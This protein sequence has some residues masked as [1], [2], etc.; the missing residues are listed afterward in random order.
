MASTQWTGSLV[1]LSGLSFFCILVTISSNYGL[2]YGYI[3][4][5][6]LGYGN[7]MINVLIAVWSTF[8]PMGNFIGALVNDRVGRVL[9]MSEYSAACRFDDRNDALTYI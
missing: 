1:L 2:D 3:V 4:Y 8:N 5:G 7:F 9:I 6:S